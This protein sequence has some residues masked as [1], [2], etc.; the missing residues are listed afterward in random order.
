MTKVPILEMEGKLVY[1]SLITADFLE[2]KF[3]H[4]RPLNSTDPFQRARDKMFMELFSK[5]C[6]KR[7]YNASD[8][9]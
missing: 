9:L 7:Y 8:Y 2:E 5:V 6:L 3:P 4:T 1:E